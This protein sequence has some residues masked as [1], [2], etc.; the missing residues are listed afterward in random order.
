MS[1][2][3]IAERL[4]SLAQLLST[5]KENPFKIKAYRR[6]AKSIATLPDSLAELARA[7]FDLTEFPGIGKGIAGA[8]A[9][10]VATGTS[11]SLTALRAKVSPEVA[12]LSEYPRLDPRRVLRIYKKLGISTT[13]ELR[14]RLDTGEIAQ[15]L[16]ARMAQHI[17][18][19]LT[20][21]NEVLLY[22]ADKI[23]PPLEDFLRSVPGVA[24]V[25]S[26]GDYRRRVETV[27]ELSFL[28]DT[29]DFGSLVSR[30]ERYGGGIE[31][32]HS[33]QRAE[34]HI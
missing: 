7:G 28:L 20:P 2:A 14:A 31:R 9:E 33:E 29:P 13:E 19:A 24:R 8:I 30:I 5:Q 26:T 15:T 27:S 17:S 16:G 12:A 32:I 3:D 10:I 25:E 6:A 34:P 22:E 23:V 21:A 1:N 18:Q 11:R 4:L